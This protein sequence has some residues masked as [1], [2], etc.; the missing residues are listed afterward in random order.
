MKNIFPVY[1]PPGI[2][3]YDVIRKLKQK[4]PGQKIGHG[5]TLDPLAEGLLIIGVGREATKQ[6]QSIL[7][8]TKKVYEVEIELGKVS[9]T[10]DA[11]GPI[12]VN[13][14]LKFESGELTRKR[15]EE[16][17]SGFIG[18]IGQTPPRYSAIKVNGVPAYKRARRGEEFV[19][20]PR[21]VIIN[22]ISILEYSY[23]FLKL[24][25]TCGSGVYIR[26]LARDIGEKL[27]TGGYVK[28]L[29]RSEVGQYSLLHV[30]QL[31]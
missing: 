15:I 30:Q 18:E 21:R 12:S 28:T 7:K 3:S 25:I 6:L 16:V 23:P 10:D 8:N 26:S 14:D 20:K 9:E 4:Y 1:K 27:G 2:S 31:P 22:D 13:G 11:E 17:L 29:K 5:G 19:L 24:K